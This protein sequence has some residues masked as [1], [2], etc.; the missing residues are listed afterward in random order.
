MYKHKAKIERLRSLSAIVFYIL[1]GVRLCCV[2]AEL[3]VM[4]CENRVLRKVCRP[5]WEETTGS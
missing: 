1:K 4:V 3:R 2:L 5:T